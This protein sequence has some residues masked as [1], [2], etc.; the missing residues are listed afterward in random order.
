[1]DKRFLKR[2]ERHIHFLAAYRLHEAQAEGGV[3]EEVPLGETFPG[4][5]VTGFGSVCF[6][7]ELEDG[8]GFGGGGFGPGRA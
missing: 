6:S 8:G 3:V 4:A 7:Q 5:I 2:P 1:M